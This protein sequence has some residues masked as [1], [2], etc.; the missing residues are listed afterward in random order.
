MDEGGGERLGHQ[1]CLFLFLSVA[2]CVISK[3]IDLT[4]NNGSDFESYISAIYSPL[5]KS[6]KVEIFSETE[7]ESVCSI[8]DNSDSDSPSSGF[9]GPGYDSSDED[10]AG[11]TS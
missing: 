6:N 2:S 9:S 3:V 5:K 7:V 4:I 10:S 11:C 8:P 1:I